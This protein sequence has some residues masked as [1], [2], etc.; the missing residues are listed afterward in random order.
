MRT[1][2]ILLGLIFALMIQPLRAAAEQGYRAKFTSTIT[3]TE[4]FDKLSRAASAKARGSE[5]D[6]DVP[7]ASSMNIEPVVGNLYYTRDK[8]R[9][10]YLIPQ[11]GMVVTTI[12]DL[13]QHKYIIVNHAQRAAYAMD[14]ASFADMDLDIG[15]PVSYPDQMFCRWHDVQQHLGAIASTKL[16]EL[17][18]KKIAGTICR[19]LAYTANLS[20]VFK[21]DGYTPLASIPPIT[22]IKGLWRGE[23]WLSEQLGLPVKMRLNL[24]GVQSQWELSE[25]EVWQPIDALLCV[26]REYAVHAITAG[27]MIRSLSLR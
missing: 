18:Q 23:F 20:D 7:L 24:L 1:M 10:D 3:I 11:N 14:F 21:A 12:V 26:P 17:G 15:L 6:G 9:V 8:F 25:I 19:G 16:K 2:S 13:Q 4:E 22:E 27:E 5:Q